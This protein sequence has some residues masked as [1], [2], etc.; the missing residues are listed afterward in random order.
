MKVQILVSTMNQKDYSLLDKL[1]I[2]SDAI[3]VNQDDH[4]SHDVFDY[5]GYRIEW[6]SVNERGVSRSRNLALSHASGD[7]CILVDD[8]EQLKNGYPEIIKESF[9][10]NSDSDIITFNIE[11]IGN[12][13]NRYY[14][15]KNKRLN[16]FNSMRYG[17][18]RIAF[19]RQ[20]IEKEQIVFSTLFGPGSVF[21]CGEDSL[22]ISDCFKRG[23]KVYSSPEVIAD[24]NDEY[25]TSSWFRG[26]N[27]K[28]FVDKGAVYA[29]MT[30]YF[31]MVY[32]SYFAL[33]H[34]KVYSN[35]V[36]FIQAI[37]WMKEGVVIYRN[38]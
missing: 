22:F 20:K 30:K 11:S 34:K 17:A 2:Q 26:Y 38:L 14:N 23:L 15:K 35:S 21:T 3:I 24:I 10:L 32:C 7:I 5:N 12:K 37:K 25:G 4:Y 6:F 33:K 19:K 1:N 16:R 36:S 18:A 9:C 8:D 27:K 13:S 31:S 29:A 28:Y